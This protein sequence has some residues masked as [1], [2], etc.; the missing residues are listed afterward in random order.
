MSHDNRAFAN[1]IRPYFV[2]EPVS[3]V[4]DAGPFGLVALIQTAAFRHTVQAYVSPCGS[5][6]LRDAS[7]RYAEDLPHEW[8]VGVYVAPLRFADIN[9]D[10]AMRLREIGW[11]P[12]LDESD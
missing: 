11:R 3:N 8:M 2:S 9:G 6:H 1:A 7:I 5:L 12:P 10:L 4:M